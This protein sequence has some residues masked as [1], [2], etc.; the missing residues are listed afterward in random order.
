MLTDTIKAALLEEL[1][2]AKRQQ[3]G[4]AIAAIPLIAG[5]FHIA[6]TAKPELLLWEKGVV[7]ALV[8]IVGGVGCWLLWKLQDHLRRT[9][10]EIDWYDRTAFWRGSEVAIGLGVALIISAIVASWS[11]WRACWLSSN[12]AIQH[13]PSP[14]ARFLL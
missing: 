3:W 14:V 9:R 13:I 12:E 4:V 11:L 8:L 1:R 6:D 5:A 10:L 2:F 7:T